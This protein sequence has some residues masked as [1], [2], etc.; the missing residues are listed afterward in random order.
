MRL[1][2]H[3]PLER[4]MRLSIQTSAMVRSFDKKAATILQH[5]IEAQPQ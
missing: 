2:I 5:G 1:R 4:L 3:S